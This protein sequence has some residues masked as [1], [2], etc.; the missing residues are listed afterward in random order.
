MYRLLNHILTAPLVYFRITV[1]VFA[2]AFFFRPIIYLRIIIVAII[3]RTTEN[4]CCKMSVIVV[5]YTAPLIHIPVPAYLS[6]GRD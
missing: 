3:S 4:T 1:I 2:I 6:R 5:I